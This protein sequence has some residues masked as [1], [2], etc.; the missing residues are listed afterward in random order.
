MLT[1]ILAKLINN[2]IWSSIPMQ[3]LKT[4]VGNMKINRNHQ[5]HRFNESGGSL[6]YRSSDSLLDLADC[7]FD[8]CIIV[9]T[10]DIETMLMEKI[11]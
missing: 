4:Q 1:Q 5:Y 9:S 8:E 11:F 6:F 2:Q 3:D 10:R 7:D